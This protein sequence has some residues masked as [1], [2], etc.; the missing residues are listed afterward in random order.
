MAEILD[1]VWSIFYKNYFGSTK[2]TKSKIQS[3]EKIDI[4]FKEVLDE[5][6]PFSN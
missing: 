6:I 5:E 3:M 2:S 1:I 4:P